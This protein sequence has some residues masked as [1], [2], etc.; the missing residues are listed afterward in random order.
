[1]ASQGNSKILYLEGIRGICAS[2]VVFTHF[3]L[4]FY[5]A[6]HYLAPEQVHTAA[7]WELLLGHG[8]ASLLISS[9]YAVPMLFVLSSYV[10]TYRYFKYQDA[11]IVRASA[12]RRYV[13][14]VLPNAFSVLACYAFMKLGLMQNLESVAYTVSP[15]AGNCYAFTPYFWDALRQG[16]WDGFFT[17]IPPEA[18]YNPATW[19][20]LYEMGG[21]FFVFSFLLLFGKSSRRW[22]MYMVSFV[23]FGQS[24]FSAFIFGMIL[25]DMHYSGWGVRI[26]RRLGAGWQLP[27]L[28][29]LV[30]FGLTGYFADGRNGWSLALDWLGGGAKVMGYD[31]W[32]LYHDLGAALMLTGI[33][34]LP[35]LQRFLQH[36]LLVFLGRISYSMYLIHMVLMCSLSC[37]IFLQLQAMGLS[38]SASVLGGALGLLAVLTPVSWLMMRL[39]DEPAI[40]LARN[41]QLR[42]FAAE[43]KPA[44]LPAHRVMK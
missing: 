3:V 22:V 5:P 17:V 2:A 27:V 29:F 6:M 28:L 4:C 37:W 31:L 13:R 7:A 34:F 1:M 11:G 30:G 10:L 16:L 41:L 18:F 21:S 25:A 24:H 32:V 35:G 9:N 20:M 44:E 14:L 26:C 36:R 8:P 38:Y 40:R 33:M 42:Y 43:T 12:W 23:L 15:W 19:T 39:V